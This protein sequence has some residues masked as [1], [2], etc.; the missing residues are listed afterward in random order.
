MLF[1][2]YN[3]LSWLQWPCW[4][5]AQA[6]PLDSTKVP[7]ILDGSG[8]RTRA[9]LEEK[10]QVWMQTE[11]ESRDNNVPLFPCVQNKW[12]NLRSELELYFSASHMHTWSKVN[13]HSTLVWCCTVKSGS[14]KERWWSWWSMNSLTALIRQDVTFWENTD[15]FSTSTSQWAVKLSPPEYWKLGHSS[16]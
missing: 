7:R 9:N 15:G 2:L 5:K 4:K 8:S 3:V 1:A 16:R 12:M 14:R 13:S 10:I 11:A 6:G